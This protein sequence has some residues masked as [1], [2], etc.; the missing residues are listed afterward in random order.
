MAKRKR[1]RDTNSA[2]VAIGTSQKPA[3]Y[4]Y[5]QSMLRQQTA[6]DCDTLIR[7][8]VERTQTLG[9]KLDN[10]RYS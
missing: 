5:V 8:I 3:S 2:P 6:Q 9:K 10:L 4:A 1:R 7:E